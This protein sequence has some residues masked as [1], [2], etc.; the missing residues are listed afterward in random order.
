MPVKSTSYTV[1]N[2]PL[3]AVFWSDVKEK[4]IYT[5]KLDGSNRRILI[6]YNESIG[7]VDGKWKTGTM[8]ERL[9]SSII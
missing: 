6:G 8:R 1:Y 3:Q 9:S 4:A 5:A 7:V 2:L